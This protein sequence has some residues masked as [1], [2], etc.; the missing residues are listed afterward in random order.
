VTEEKKSVYDEHIK[1][2]VD[3][4][5]ELCKKHKMP[6]IFTIAEDIPEQKRFNVA[7]NSGCPEGAPVPNVMGLM[8]ACTRLDNAQVEMVGSSIRQ[9]VQTNIAANQPGHG[10][11]VQ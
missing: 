2:E 3:S 6:F 9:L 11:T 5:V 8:I 7:F 10:E 4:L 1:Q